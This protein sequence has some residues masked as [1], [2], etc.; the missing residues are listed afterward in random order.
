MDYL[1][2]DVM[3][4][5][6]RRSLLTGAAVAGAGTMLWPR[7]AP[8]HAAAPAVGKQAPG[9]YRYKVGDLEI[10][11]FADGARTFLTPDTFVVNASKDQAIAAAQAAYLPTGQ[12]TVPFNPL[13]V[14][15]DV[16]KRPA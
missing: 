5:L 13:R 12:V 1:R 15:N 4:A 11:Q 8:V 9:F 10:T 3:A 16:L 6:T 2:G 7:S 14:A